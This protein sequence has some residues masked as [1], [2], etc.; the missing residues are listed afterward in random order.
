ME[1]L[2]DKPRALIV[3]DS[4]FQRHMLS[5]VCT[6][7]GYLTVLVNN[8]KEALTALQEMSFKLIVSDLEMPEMDGL[9]LIRELAKLEVQSK[10][11]FVSGHSDSLLGAA[12]ELAEQFGLS[13]AGTLK[14]PY[15]PENFLQLLMDTSLL[16]PDASLNPRYRGHFQGQLSQQ[17]VIQGIHEGAVTPFYQP[18]ICRE[19]KSL[20][21][22]ECLA[23]WDTGNGRVLG[24]GSF[25]PTAEQHSLMHELTDAIIHQALKDMAVWQEAGHALE[26]SINISTDDLK[27]IEFPDRLE[28][29]TRK[30]SIEPRNII[31]EVTETKV[32]E[33][34]RECLEVM[35][36]LRLRGF[37]LSIDDFG[38]G[39]ASLKQLQYF[40][41]TELKLDRSYVAAAVNHKPSLA[42]LETGIQ[43]AKNLSLSCIA[44]GIET[45]EQAQFLVSLGCPMHQGFLYAQPLP[46]SEV[47]PWIAERFHDSDREY[48]VLSSYDLAHQ[49]K[50]NL[51]KAAAPFISAKQLVTA[52]EN[53]FKKTSCPY[54]NV[55]S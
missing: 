12:K 24:P 48:R 17:T 50:T 19:S 38:T 39:Y 28:H 54:P 20:K 45:E 33:E 49:K 9:Q 15:V 35:S 46:R 1:Q 11:V 26:I 23:R 32:M 30:Y 6:E 3:D 37:G 41:F 43:L 10:I 16:N 27:D 22:F 18:K 34:A 5:V 55:R 44:E 53:Y 25:I 40:P 8:G 14:K 21:G 7:A 51:A 36:R 4:A 29:L 2:P 31:L 47:L 42:V 13:I 52:N